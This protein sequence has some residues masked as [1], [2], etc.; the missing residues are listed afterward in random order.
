MSVVSQKGFF[1]IGLA[2]GSEA[3]E[4]GRYG[5]VRALLM[6]HVQSVL[7][8]YNHNSSPQILTYLLL[9]QT[10]ALGGCLSKP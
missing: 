4:L 6:A 3:S 10:T 5:T 7:S 8:G 9:R 1:I 2:S